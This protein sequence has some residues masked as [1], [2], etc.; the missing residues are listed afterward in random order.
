MRAHR[1]DRFIEAEAE[2][3]SRHLKKTEMADGPDLDTGAVIAHGILQT[4]FHSLLIAVFLHIDEIDH[5]QARQ[6][7]KAKLARQFLGRLKIGLQGRFLDVALARRPARVDVDGDK[8]LGLVDHQIATRFQGHLR[9]VDGVHLLLDLIALEDRLLVFVFL[10]PFDMAWDQHLHLLTGFLVAV[11][12]LDDH[13]IHFAGV[14][15]ADRPFYKIA[16]LMDQARRL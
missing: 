1:G 7:T 5:D 15:I 16:F 12:A 14:Q 13:L 2:P 10:D 4:P 11:L 9:T 6:V 3:L 8:R